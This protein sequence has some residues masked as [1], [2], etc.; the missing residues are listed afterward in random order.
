MSRMD[1][2]LCGEFVE[3]VEFIEFVGFVGV[4][5]VRC[6]GVGNEWSVSS[7]WWFSGG[8]SVCRDKSTLFQRGES[9]VR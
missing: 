3:F 5:G 9:V 6:S 1:G 8:V 2:G 4:V 7:I